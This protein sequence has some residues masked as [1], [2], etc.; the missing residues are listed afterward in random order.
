MLADQVHFHERTQPYHLGL[1]QRFLTVY[2]FHCRR[3][4]TGH[5]PTFLAFNFMP[6]RYNTYEHLLLNAAGT[7]L[8]RPSDKVINEI[9]RTTQFH[10]HRMILTA[11]LTTSEFFSGACVDEFVVAN[12]FGGRRPLDI[13][14]AGI[15]KRRAQFIAWPYCV[16]PAER[17]LLI[18]IGSLPLFSRSF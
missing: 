8:G 6:S 12:S 17:S 2:L 4:S 14:T 10:A 9:G 1:G 7:E 15:C 16:R 13:M 5:R 11:R 3:R 18:F